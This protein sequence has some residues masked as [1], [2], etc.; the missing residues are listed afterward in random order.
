MVPQ[1]SRGIADRSPLPAKLSHSRSR[2]STR[3]LSRV[4]ND[5]KLNPKQE[6]IQQ[7]IRLSRHINNVFTFNQRNTQIHRDN[8]TLKKKLDA[9][10]FKGTGI[11]PRADS[12]ASLSD[13]QHQQRL[14]L[15]KLQK[16]G[17]NELKLMKLKA[18]GSSL[19]YVQQKR[20]AGRIDRENLGLARRMIQ[21]KPMEQLTKQRLDREY[22][23]QA[24]YGRKLASQNSSINI[25]QRV[26]RKRSNR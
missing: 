6:Y 5:Y 20:E 11:C 3:S 18:L 24:Q 23:R 14:D 8:L 22:I 19:N 25:E 1:F 15:K 7:A 2:G 12:R 17:P 9:I 21:Q 16:K 10:H 26:L 13:Y 4:S